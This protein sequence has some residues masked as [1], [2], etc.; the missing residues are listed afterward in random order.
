MPVNSLYP[1]VHIPN[2]D[3]FTFLFERKD[4]LYPDEKSESPFCAQND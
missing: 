2:V 4:K 1:D 3:L